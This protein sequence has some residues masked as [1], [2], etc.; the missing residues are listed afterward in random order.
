MNRL[1]LTSL[2]TALALAGCGPKPPLEGQQDPYIPK[3]IHLVDVDL[4]PRVRFD[5]PVYARDP[6]GLLYITIQVRNTTDQT[7]YIDYRV[8]FLDDNKQVVWQTTWLNKTLSARTF[9]RISVN[10]T[11]PRA[12]DFQI[13]VRYAKITGR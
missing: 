12:T 10:S 6:A 7:I 8:T 11:S 3:Q 13:D 1:L 5:E 9:D 2:L 4:A